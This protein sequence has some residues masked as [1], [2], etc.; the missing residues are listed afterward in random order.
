[1][2]L[3]S[4]R[5]ELSVEPGKDFSS[6]GISV[7]SKE[8]IRIL[9][10][11]IRYLKLTVNKMQLKGEETGQYWF[12][13][14]LLLP[15]IM[16]IGFWLYRKRMEKIYG[17][18][19]RLLFETAGREASRRL[20]KAQTLLEQGNTKDYYSEISKA[21][22]GY[23]EHKLRIDKA[24]FIMDEALMQ[25]K[26]KGIDEKTINSLKSCIEKV[27]YVRYAPGSDTIT[28]RKELLD[29]AMVVIKK[30]EEN[31]TKRAKQ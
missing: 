29:S 15:Q 7:A 4:P 2:T 16:F 5:F 3:N 28:A 9:G 24:K 10:E 20:K 17:D 8:E 22:I 6:S 12:I 1:M 13:F 31:F 25:L 11:D 30:I 14:A 18:L 26:E 23:L 19:P 21:L 27:E